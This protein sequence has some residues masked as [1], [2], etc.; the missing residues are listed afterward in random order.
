M[1]ARET[2]RQEG[3]RFFS[4]PFKERTLFLSHCLRAEQK[5]EIQK[6]AEN[7]GYNVHIVG[8]GSIVL[9]LIKKEMPRAVVGIACYPELKMAVGELD[10][11]LQVI[12]LE[13]DGCKDTTVNVAEAKRILSRFI[14]C[15]EQ[16]NDY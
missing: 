11:P 8:G 16:K 2:N 14:P 9:K 1:F 4:I 7:L 15:K 3:G 5:A 10:L 12:E 13:T 6:F